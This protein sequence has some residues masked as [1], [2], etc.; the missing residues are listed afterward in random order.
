MQAKKVLFWAHEINRVEKDSAR[1]SLQTKLWDVCHGVAAPILCY[2]SPPPMTLP[3]W[4]IKLGIAQQSVDQSHQ[5]PGGKRQGSF[6]IMLGCFVVLDLVISPVLRLMHPHGVGCL[7]QV[8]PEVGISC[9]SQR[10]LFSGEISRLMGAPSQPGESMQHFL[11]GWVIHY[12]YFRPHLSLNDRT[13]AQTAGIDFP[14]RNWKELI[15]KQPYSVTARI[16][17]RASPRITPPRPRITPKTP[18]LRR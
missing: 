15:E 10:R 11:D 13:P 4:E 9:F 17:V 6:V 5:L 12:N 1:V 8:V 2:D 14:Y 18:R 16:P 7:H 3:G